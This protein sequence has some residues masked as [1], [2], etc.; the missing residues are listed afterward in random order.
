M[1]NKASPGFTLIEVLVAM[2]ILSIALTAI[3]KSTM[4]NIKDTLYLQ[5][6]TIALW[7]GNQVINEVQA[8][9]HKLPMAPDSL[10]HKSIMLNETWSWEAS[11][12]PTPNPRIQEITVTVY[13]KAPLIHLVSYLYVQQ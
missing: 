7:V 2:V 6:K 10:K 5:N 1:K 9:L 11:L 4:Q 3:I 13:Q 12:K 8:G